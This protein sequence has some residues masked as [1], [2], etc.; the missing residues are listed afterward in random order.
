MVQPSPLSAYV[1]GTAAA[2]A[3][4]CPVRPVI[5]VSSGTRLPENHATTRRST[6]MKTI[7]SP[8]PTR[9]RAASAVP[10]ESANANPTWPR[11]IRLSPVNRM[12]RAPYRSISSPTGI[13]MST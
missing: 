11:V 9:T 2:T 1:I 4:S 8:V 12:R 7:A 3:P 5:W 6:L 10:Y 13:C